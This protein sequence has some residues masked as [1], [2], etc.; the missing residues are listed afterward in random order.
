MGRENSLGNVARMAQSIKFLGAAETVTGSRHLLTL[1]DKHVLVDC[2]LFQGTREL[3]DR[4]WQ[5]FPI[6]PSEIDCIVLTHAH[7][8]HVGYV[9]KLVR[10]GFRG[11]IYCTKATLGLS[12]ISLPDS[13]RIQEEDARRA[14]RHGSK[15]QPALPLYTEDDAYNC[16]KQFRTLKY[17][18]L[19]SL[20]GGA[21]FRFYPAG[22]I[23]GSAFA[24]IFFDNGERILMGGDL[25]RY[26]T[27]I[28]KDPTTIESAEYLVLESTYGDRLH[29][30]ENVMER[31][32]VILNDAMRTGGAILT[33]SFSI[34]RTQELMYYLHELQAAGRMPRI[35][36]FIDS[37]MAVSATELY[38]HATEEFDDEMEKAVEMKQ[39][40]LEPEH[41]QFVRDQE[42]SKALNAQR[43]PLMIIAGSGMATGGRILHHFVH[44]LSDPTTIV[45]FTGFQAQGTLGRRLIEGASEVR[46][47]GQEVEVKARVDKLNSLSAHAD[48]G[49]ILKWLHG[50]KTPP[51]ETFIVHG[52]PPAQA[53]LQAKITEELGWKT[54]IPKW[55]EEFDL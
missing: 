22:H 27:P 34:G 46:I 37:P 12:R 1:N 36:V 48:Q 49:E 41:V 38:R 13:G 29:A 30:H 3:K 51:R 7:L 8:D 35:P 52:E 28:I 55:C 11:A 32:E 40:P 19:Q 54:V 26:D 5:P 4:N 18:Q 42:M 45:L 16:L 24:E 47:F 23:L 39:S 31:L 25:G 21:Q 15:H 9:P 17:E 43:G 20:P 50:F 10:D 6:H 14:N 53:A 44:R 2:G 33:P